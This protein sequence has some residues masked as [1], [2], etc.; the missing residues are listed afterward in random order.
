MSDKKP[1]PPA[2]AEFA[3]EQLAEAGEQAA[4]DLTV[5]NVEILRAEIER[6][7]ARIVELE[8]ERNRLLNN[9]KDVFKKMCDM[10]LKQRD[11]FAAELAAL[12]ATSSGVVLDGETRHDAVKA[13]HDVMEAVPCSSLYS[14]A[15]A[16]LDAGY[17]L[18]PCR[19]G[20]VLPDLIAELEKQAEEIAREGHAGWG[21]TMLLAAE[22]LS[23][24]G[25]TAM[26][27]TAAPS[28]RP[29]KD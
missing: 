2:L 17:S 8:V 14:M 11:E 24:A 18:N 20:V 13:I 22:A 9:P 29:E 10:A 6:R 19:A 16:V 23:V 21:N 26:L 5:Q 7:E 28:A 12:K 1:V 27:A 4:I 15:E 3:L 25:V